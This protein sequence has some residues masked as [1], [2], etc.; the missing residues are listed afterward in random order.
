MRA[1]LHQI[2][3][4]RSQE[5]E[6]KLG[7]SRHP[8]NKLLSHPRYMPHPEIVLPSDPEER[9]DYE[10]KLEA[11]DWRGA[12]HLLPTPGSS[13]ENRIR[14]LLKYGKSIAA[15]HYGGLLHWAYKSAFKGLDAVTTEDLRLLF[16]H[17][18]SE[19]LG[20]RTENGADQLPDQL[21][22]YRGYHRPEFKLRFS[23]ATSEYDAARF[24]LL[25]HE[26]SGHEPRI[27]CGRAQKADAITF[28]GFELEVIIDPQK[29]EVVD[30]YPVPEALWHSWGYSDE[31]SLFYNKTPRSTAPS[32][33]LNPLE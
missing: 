20:S 5:Q 14:F 21:T 23:W 28:T 24:A 32:K 3:S 1:D 4:D 30:D 33:G 7:V 6:Q 15:E 13:C 18:G 29:V 19:S 10:R 22:L 16:S 2:R 9:R 27:V 8:V 26:H 12:F 31:W 11:G 25:W 17:P